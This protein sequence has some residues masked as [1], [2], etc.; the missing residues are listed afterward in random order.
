MYDLPN[1]LLIGLATFLFGGWI[2]VAHLVRLLFSGKMRTE[3]EV[4]SKDKEL[5][6][7]KEVNKELL[8]QNT[9]MVREWLPTANAIL[10]AIRD[11]A[12][13]ERS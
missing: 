7:L 12:N 8:A 2:L 9:L 11:T 5:N 3:R 6:D 4:V 1:P 10:T 13:R